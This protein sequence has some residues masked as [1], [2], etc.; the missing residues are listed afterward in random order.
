M[1][2]LTLTPEDLEPFATITRAKAEAMIVDAL[3][4]AIDVAPCLSDPNLADAKRDAAKAI[5]R[6]A[7]LRWNDTGSGALQTQAA[8]PFSVG[9]DTR[10]PGGGVGKLWPTEIRDL[11]RICRGQPGGAFAVD[12][13]PEAVWDLPGNRLPLSGQINL[14]EPEW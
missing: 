13:V 3:A 14:P 4:R 1:A 11:Q 2:A 6:G 8:G 10:Q 9:L 5:L 7:V 12:T